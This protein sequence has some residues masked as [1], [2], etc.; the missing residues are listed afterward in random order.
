MMIIKKYDRVVHISEDFFYN[1]DKRII[2]SICASCNKY[3]SLKSKYKR[4]VKRCQELWPNYRYM[5]FTTSNTS[6]SPL[7]TNQLKE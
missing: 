6:V 1:P 5:D 3:C 4:M 7:A 2:V